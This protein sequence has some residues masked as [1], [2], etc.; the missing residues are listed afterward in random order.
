MKGKNIYKMLK[1]I[2][3]LRRKAR[4]MKRKF[5]LSLDQGTTGTRAI[6]YDENANVFSQAYREITQYYPHPGWVEQ[7]P[8]E[9]WKSSLSC[10]EE[11]LSKGNLTSSSIAAIGITNQRE[12]TVV[13]D[14]DTGRPVYNAIV[15]QC[16]RSAPL[17]EKLKARGLGETIREKT[18]LVVDAYFSATKIKWIL[19]HLKGLRERAQKGQIAFGTVDSFLLWRLTAGKFHLTDYTNASR[20]MLFNIGNLRWDEELLELLDIPRQMLPEVRPSSGIYGYTAL[21]GPIEPGIP[22]AAL[23]GDQQAALFGQACFSPGTVKNTY[24]T[25]CFLL[26]NTGK[27]PSASSGHLL[28]TL[29]CGKNG[30]LAYALEGSVFTAGAAVQW[31]RDGL[32]LIGKAEETEDMARKVEDTKGVYVVPAFTGL[33][34]PYWDMSAKGAI[35]GLTRGVGKEHIIRAT[36]EA[37]AYQVRDVLEVMERE[38]G[39]RIKTLKVDGGA[40][41]NDFLMQFQA[42][43][44]NVPVER[45][46]VLETTSLGAAFLAGLAMGFWKDTDELSSL[47]KRDVLFVPRMDEK[48]RESLYKGWRRAVRCIL[49]KK[50]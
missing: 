19:D 33:G 13:W 14:R 40:A 46:A 15:W 42:D 36:L 10:I 8:E 41:K 47:W 50:S 7:D 16:R 11:A 44:L 29:A 6:L 35:L 37:I 21:N 48:K 45:P 31:L 18:G 49:E 43:I 1:K 30:K 3:N 17:C 9:I 20:T 12:T 34:A 25:G 26:L 39:M 2:Y 24:G 28:T 5:I 23:V 27:R 32:G 22:I 4:G 38:S